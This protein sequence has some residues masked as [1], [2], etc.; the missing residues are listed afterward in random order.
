MSGE[1]MHRDGH[2]VL[3]DLASEKV[4]DIFPTFLFY[5]EG[6]GDRFN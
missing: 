4:L 1:A 3:E 5:F 2:G 6:G